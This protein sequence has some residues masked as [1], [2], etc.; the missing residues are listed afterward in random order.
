MEFGEASGVAC[1][2]SGEQGHV[3]SPVA[4]VA[5]AAESLVAGAVGGATNLWSIGRL[6]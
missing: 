4:R 2:T 6:Q 5:G 3:L 1:E